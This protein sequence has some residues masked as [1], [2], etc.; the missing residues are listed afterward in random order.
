[1]KKIVEK[2]KEATGIGSN[3]KMP[4]QW[5]MIWIVIGCWLVPVAL[6]AAGI[7]NIL[8]EQINNQIENTIVTS[9]DKAIEISQL[10][11]ADIIQ[12]SKN[13]S[14]MP[15][16]KE[17]YNDYLKTG[18]KQKLY[19]SVTNF[20]AQ[21]Y[22]N[23]PNLMY[24]LI[25]FVDDQETMYYTYS[26]SKVNYSNIR[27]FKTGYMDDVTAVTENL[28]TGIAMM[29]EEGHLYLIRN[30]VDSTYKPY[31]VTVLEL[32]TDAVFES[33]NSIWG[34]VDY[35]IYMDGVKIAGEEKEWAEHFVIPDSTMKTSKYI[36][37]KEES[38]VY[39]VVKEGK[40]KFGYRVD[41]DTQ[42]ILDETSVVRYV[43][44]IVVI[45]MLPII[46]MIFWF[47]HKKVTKP[48]QYLVEASDE[49]A[50]GHYG[51][52][53][54]AI[55]NSKEFE[56]LYRS[57][58]NMS[59]KL[60]EQFEKIYLEDLALKD[61]KIM[62]LQ[63]QINPHFLNN[64]LEIINWEARM[65]GNDKVSGMIEALSTMLNATMNRKQKKMITLEE[66]LTYVEAYLHII[67]Q[68]F[69][70]RFEVEK[71]IDESLLSVEVPR[72]II[73]PI[74]E[75]AVEHG[76]NRKDPVARV[77]MNIYQK[78]D[79]LYIE[80]VNNG[81]MSKQDR[82]RIEELLGGTEEKEEER[83]TS[84]GIRNVDRRIK[85]IYGNNCGLT[86]KSTKEFETVS[87]I[88]VKINNH[89]NKSQ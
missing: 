67:E 30:L 79:K 51:E 60:Q 47:F 34:C 49:I 33:L 5:S 19:T 55:S 64:T 54:R 72:L 70:D 6:G 32:N 82:L 2:I 53:I 31:A 81:H 75:N 50:K 10:Q 18:E 83:S 8:S 25:Y 69:G 68:R 16:I 57:Y 35:T 9:S 59:A 71:D 15:T 11:L 13:S 61:A 40:Y 24:A 45:F 52:K 4:L 56:Y 37:T 43:S 27:E 65:N 38:Y 7:L 73:Q 76:A 28:G 14:Y 12:A 39:K 77:K 29:K 21:Q 20:L 41:L 74:I 89:H 17:S 86:I 1:M 22:K 36:H 84:L 87:T 44:T 48:I 85:I 78:L 46:C 88:V 62:A 42:A 66:E 63:S 26:N 80:I 58:D 3:G 23:N